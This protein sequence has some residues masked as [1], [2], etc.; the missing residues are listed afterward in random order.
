MMQMV[1]ADAQSKPSALAGG[2]HLQVQ[3]HSDQMSAIA[4]VERLKQMGHQ[5]HIDETDVDGKIW[6]RVNIGD[7]PD[8]VAA[9]TAR[10]TLSEQGIADTLIIKNSP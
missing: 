10:D 8:R 3:S 2:Y 4:S 7:F 5:A 6:Y 9:Q 1:P